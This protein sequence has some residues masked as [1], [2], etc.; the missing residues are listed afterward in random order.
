M[1]IR[2]GDRPE[3][4]KYA[5]DSVTGFCIFGQARI[6]G[7]TSVPP[8]NELEYLQTRLHFQLLKKQQRHYLGYG[9]FTLF[10]TALQGRRWL[11]L[12]NYSAIG[13]RIAGLRT[14]V[15]SHP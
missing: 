6:C 14:S 15:V 9:T 1:R 5:C 11:M 2:G 3:H 4:C 7:I 12:T 13:F 10:G 8:V